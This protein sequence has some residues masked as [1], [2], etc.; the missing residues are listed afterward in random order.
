MYKLILCVLCVSVKTKRVEAQCYDNNTDTPSLVRTSE[1]KNYYQS[2]GLNERARDRRWRFLLL[3]A[4]ERRDRW[5]VFRPQFC[6]CQKNEFTFP[7]RNGLISVSTRVV[8]HVNIVTIVACN[9]V[10]NLLTHVPAHVQAIYQLLPI[11]TYC[12]TP[13]SY[14]ILI[15]IVVNFRDRI[16][17]CLHLLLFYFEG[18]GML[19]KIVSCKKRVSNT[20]FLYYSNTIC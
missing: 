15:F 16:S 20:R 12:I 8:T 2:N 7:T 18:R 9:A 13:W 6:H 3:R 19:N 14:K 11:P 5:V 4:S 10:N 17:M 1:A